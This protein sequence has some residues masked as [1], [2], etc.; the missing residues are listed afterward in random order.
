MKSSS[1]LSTLILAAGLAG[2]MGCSILPSPKMEPAKRYMF[3]MDAA[4]LEKA[5]DASRAIPTIHIRRLAAASPFKGRAFVYKLAENRFEQ[6]MYHIFISPPEGLL[7]EYIAQSFNAQRA[8]LPVASST[9]D[10]ILDGVVESLYGDYTDKNTP[11]AVIAIRFSLFTWSSK[12]TPVFLET[13][14]AR[15]PLPDNT[16]D[17]LVEGWNQALADIMNQLANHLGQKEVRAAIKG[18][19]VIK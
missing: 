1:T 7:T 8:A 6:D 9:A 19:P 14:S 2:L 3:S 16:A 5:Q 15:H 13:L 10:L 11:A 17:A 4:A 12:N 18:R